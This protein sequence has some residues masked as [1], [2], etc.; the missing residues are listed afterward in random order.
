VPAEPEEGMISSRRVAM[1]G[2]TRAHGASDGRFERQV[3]R[4]V[5]GLPRI[6]RVG[7]RGSRR[8]DMALRQEGIRLA[9]QEKKL[10][11]RQEPTGQSLPQLGPHLGARRPRMGTDPGMF[12]PRPDRDVFA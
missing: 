2:G 1:Q 8:R 12:R 7:A 9:P 10:R 11:H 4:V 5:A 6:A 3:A